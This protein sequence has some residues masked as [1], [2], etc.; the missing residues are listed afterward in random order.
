MFPETRESDLDLKAL[1]AQ[2][3]ERKA[4]LMAELAP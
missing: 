3:A 1:G 4:A 2:M